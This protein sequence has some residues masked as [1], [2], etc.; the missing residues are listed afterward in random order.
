MARPD[1]GKR[2]PAALVVLISALLATMTAT[3]ARPAAALGSISIASWSLPSGMAYGIGLDAINQADTSPGGYERYYEYTPGGVST[4][5]NNPQMPGSF[6]FSAGF[7]LR[8]LRMEIYEFEYPKYQNSGYSPYHGDGAVVVRVPG[9]VSSHNLGQIQLPEEGNGTVELSGTVLARGGVS[10]GRTKLE[11]F[12][13]TGSRVTTTGYRLDAFSAGENLEGGSYTSGPLWPGQYIAFVVDQ[14]TGRTAIGLLDLNANTTLDLDL[15]TT[16]YGLDECQFNGSTPAATPGAFHPVGPNRI[17]D[18]RRGLGIGGAVFPGDG[19]NSDPNN[20]KRDA[21]RLNHEFRIAGVGGV[22][23]AGVGAVLANVTVTG[24]T[25]SGRASL[26]PKPARTYVFGDQTSYGVNPPGSTIYWD[27]Y[28]DVPNLMVLPVGVGG[29]VRID[30][31][32]LG[33]LDLVVDVVGWFDHQQPGQTGSRL[34]V[35]P[36]TRLLD[37][38][39]AIGMTGSFQPDQSRDLQVAGVAG[40][41][42]S[43]TAVV[44]TVTGVGPTSQTFLTVHPQGTARQETSVVNVPSGGIRPN[45]VTIGVGSGGRWSIYNE[46]GTHDVLFDVSGYFHPTNGGLVT[47]IRPVQVLDATLGQN[48]TRAAQVTGVG[49]IPG[50]ISAVYL[51]VT[52]ERTTSYS[53]L[54]V[55]GLGTQPIVSNVN[56]TQGGQNRANL[57]LVPVASDGTVRIFNAFGNA[58]V[59]ASVVAYVS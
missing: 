19:R 47:P 2:R 17:V 18:T 16:C 58:A 23:A 32:S 27:P 5:P 8:E 10:A 42:S 29:R 14:V 36:P 44:G 40:V 25:A 7:D 50:G 45:L 55:W 52:A 13:V 43:V 46:R 56:W 34:S 53:Y 6:S 35:V 41:P 33:T 54:T 31:L 37:S 12:Q 22:P 39:N 1:P 51:N 57:V 15:D 59:T 11:I 3:T 21:S 26:F 30:N 48:V 28:E 24:A 38:R 4:D 9:N 49:G 20:L